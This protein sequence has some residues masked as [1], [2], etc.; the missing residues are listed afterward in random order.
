MRTGPPSVTPVFNVMIDIEM[1][2][3][4]GGSSIAS[5]GSS[6]SRRIWLAGNCDFEVDSL[7]NVTYDVMNSLLNWEAMGLS[8]D[9]NNLGI[10]L[11]NNEIY[12]ILLIE[13]GVV[14]MVSN[15]ATLIESYIKS[16]DFSDDFSDEFIDG[17]DT[18]FTEWY[19]E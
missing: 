12:Y 13:L 5:M 1:K 18:A 6:N 7:A 3:S 14:T 11:D 10:V 17:F 8:D 4:S 16:S 2:Y 15:D 9:F 19:D